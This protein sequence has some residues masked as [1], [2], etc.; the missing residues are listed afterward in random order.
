MQRKRATSLQMDS[1]VQNEGEYDYVPEHLVSPF[2]VQSRLKSKGHLQRVYNED[3]IDMGVVPP[4][5]HPGLISRRQSDPGRVSPARLRYG[6]SCSS[7]DDE[8][9]E[10]SPRSY[11]PRHFVGPV[12]EE[13]SYLTGTMEGRLSP[14]LS[15]SPRRRISHQRYNA[16]LP[17]NTLM[18]DESP[19]I[20]PRA[21]RS[22]SLPVHFMSFEVGEAVGALAKSPVSTDAI[23]SGKLSSEN[24]KSALAAGTA[25][26]ITSTKRAHVSRWISTEEPL[27]ESI[28]EENGA[29]VSKPRR[30]SMPQCFSSEKYTKALP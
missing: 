13:D 24:S 15:S 8:E 27:L 12:P 14:G 30:L 21:F 22:N 3:F 25:A 6:G 5:K 2:T 7:S 26:S 17:V 29:R 19:R 23:K 28:L 20:R 16:S 9:Y 10:R 18:G 4:A 1:Q 11:S